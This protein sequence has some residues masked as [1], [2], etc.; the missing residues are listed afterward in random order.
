MTEAPFTPVDI[1]Q[2]T[3][4]ELTIIRGIGPGLA[5]R[6][7]DH[8]PYETIE[9]LVRVPGINQIKLLALRP[10]ITLEEKKAKPASRKTAPKPQTDPAVPSSN[11]GETETFVFL[12]NRDERQDALLI[13]FGGFI[14]GLLIL[15][16]RRS[17]R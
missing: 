2:A 11:L 1:N 5:G 4:I 13:I 12:E 8:R 16:L 3:L 7:V 10:F 17:R 14:L 6:I 9:D 15:M